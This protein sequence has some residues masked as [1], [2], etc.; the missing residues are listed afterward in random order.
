MAAT[1]CPR[2][3]RAARAGEGACAC[4]EVFAPDSVRATAVAT[5]PA[6]AP[7]PPGTADAPTLATVR[8]RRSV[9]DDPTEAPTLASFEVGERAGVFE[10]AIGTRLGSRYEIEAVLGTGGM[11]AVY[12]ARDLELNR[13]VALKV[14][15]PELLSNPE[16]VD[17]FKREVLLASQVTHRNVLRI[18]D[19]GEAGHL[20]FLSMHYVDG[21]DLHEILRRDGPLPFDK[22][23]PIVRQI[24]GALQAAHDAGVVHRDLK[25]RNILIDAAGVPY[26]ADFGISRPLDTGKTMT[27][28]GAILGTIKYMSPEQARG[29]TPGPRSDIYSLGVMMYEIFTGRLPF[30]GDNELSV[31]MKR[32]HE[33][34]PTVR[35]ALPQFP[36]W[37]SS[38]VA[39]ALK[40]NP[41]ERYQSAA[42]L[43][44]DLDRQHATRSWKRP[45]RSAAMAAGAVLAL[46][47]LVMG[48]RWFSAPQSGTA[49][50]PV[51]PVASLLVM[52]LRN[53]TGE[54]RFD[55][56]REGL[57]DLLRSDLAQ[58]KALRIAGSERV[59]EALAGLGIP[60]AEESR[61][62]SVQRIGKLVGV[63][64]VVTGSLL[65][66]G[67]RFRLEASI[68]RIGPTAAV[69]GDPIVLE[70]EGEEAIFSLVDDLTERIRDELH[71]SGGWRETDQ[72]VAEIST[73]SVAALGHYSEGLAL[74]RAGNLLEAAARLEKAVE[75]DPAF[76]LAHALLAQT[77]DRLGQGDRAMAE[78]AKAVETMG[79][80]SSYEASRIRAIAASLS[81]DLEGAA[82]AYRALTEA[83]PND[84][85]A[86]FDLALIL[87]EAGKLEEA[88]PAMVRV[89]E[90][91]PRNPEAHYAL[92]RLRA[93][94]GDSAAALQELTAAL[95]IHAEAGNEAG[96]ATV[97]NGIGNTFLRIDRHDD[98]LE[99]F[100]QSLEIRR[101]LGDQGGVRVV[102]GNIALIQSIKG[103]YDGAIVSA[104]ESL[105]ISETIGDAIGVAKAHTYLGDIHQQ[106]G[107]TTDALV[108]YQE[109]LRLAREAGDEAVLAETLGSLGFIHGV[110]GRYVESYFFHKEALEKK[111]EIGDKREMTIALINVAIAE[112]F[113]GRYEE[114]LKFYLEALSLGKEID[115]RESVAVASGNTSNINEDQGRYG[116]ALEQLA[117]ALAIARE[118]ED[119]GLVA[120]FLAY[121]GSTKLRLGDMKGADAALEE[122]IAIAREIQSIPVLAEALIYRGES[123]L[124]A[125]DVRRSL[126]V[127]NE[128]VAA[129]KQ[130][131]EH[132]LGL[133]ARLVR[134]EARRS[135]TELQGILREADAAG[136]K[137]Y[138]SRARLA[139]GRA[140][141]EGGRAGEALA[142]A[143]G[144]VKMATSLGQKDLLVQAHHVAARALSARGGAGDLDKAVAHYEGAVTALLEVSSQLP[145]QLRSFLLA[146]PST[147]SLLADARPAL[148]RAGRDEA[149]ALFEVLR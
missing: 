114:A 120:L 92:G 90:L 11:G 127:M 10:I 76:A 75:E 48:V 22:A 74:S 56:I 25:P 60:L 81:G 97:L 43:L 13:T 78:A 2:C 118:M 122:A 38:V 83:A 59:G 32:V 100:N 55:W 45:L 82:G 61:P 91:D 148:E 35:S 85:Q 6:E 53:A 149:V 67:N 39:R 73:G 50:A 21:T 105:S 71:V 93:K 12:R 88:L 41:D 111:R 1:N 139:L 79:K 64:N 109:G 37:L 95:G 68:M 30:S 66:A 63:E 49:A 31:M 104:R 129:A 27:G 117:G 24:A 94:T 147:A 138:V 121:T 108:E 134:G 47:G 40:R 42:D 116:A 70:G 51:A 19:L 144:A 142:Q 65:R 58:A 86:H 115:N 141:L 80:T 26:I 137:P 3:G 15:R 44:R 119:Q 103:D 128:A 101:R 84:A 29:E 14:I 125:A 33:D 34:A 112:Q 113:Q 46:A 36:L 132:R 107:R 28:T 57:T 77:Y 89:V 4:G 136:L 135:A 140:L 52:P 8:H 98:A 20:K 106:A 18:H 146:R 145:E 5:D 72:A 16:A 130:A 99:N 9:S 17:R 102:L 7:T 131:E 96:R 110:M 87:E 126:E 124:A 133:L 62:A 123:L 23:L 54:A 69:P 143:E